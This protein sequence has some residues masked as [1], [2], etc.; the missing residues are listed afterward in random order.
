MT[1]KIKVEKPYNYCIR[2]RQYCCQVC[3]SFD[4]NGISLCSYFH[5]GR[6]CP[7]C[8]GK[9][10]RY[11]HI[12]YFYQ[13]EKYNKYLNEIKNLENEFNSKIKDV[14]EFMDKIKSIENEIKRSVCDLENNFNKSF[15]VFDIEI[16]NVIN[17]G[18]NTWASIIVDE[19]YNLKSEFENKIFQV[20]N[21]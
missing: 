1:R 16:K 20:K 10:P 11:C 15:N 2:C 5:N 4:D 18:K 19:L 8:P 9:C 17:L 21:Y 13:E 14:N 6:N 12:K 3:D 7:R